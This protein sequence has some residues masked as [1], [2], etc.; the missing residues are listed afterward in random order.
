MA[1]DDDDDLLNESR[2]GRRIIT[3]CTFLQVE[4]LVA[5]T[6][7]SLAQ[8]ETTMNSARVLRLVLRHDCQ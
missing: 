6:L 3:V 2:S 1:D 4:Q 8:Q 7:A 5:E